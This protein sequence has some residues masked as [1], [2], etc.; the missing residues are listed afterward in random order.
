MRWW[1]EGP[2]IVKK[3]RVTG[4]W[5]YNT[6][7]AGIVR[8]VKIQGG[9]GE[10]GWVK[11]LTLGGLSPGEAELGRTAATSVKGILFH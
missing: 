11:L 6:E 2:G 7:P 5:Q 1:E 4:K 8:R 9:R 3:V 10:E